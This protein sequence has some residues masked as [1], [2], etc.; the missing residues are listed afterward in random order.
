MVGVMAAASVRRVIFSIVGSATM[1]GNRCAC[2]AG[3]SRA[4]RCWR[5]TVD[6]ATT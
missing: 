2:G 4:T 6:A 5:V 3:A 1:L